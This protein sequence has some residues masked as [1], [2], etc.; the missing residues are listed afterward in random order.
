MFAVFNSVFV[1]SLKIRTQSAFE[2]RLSSQK[3]SLITVS[4]QVGKQV[5]EI[6]ANLHNIKQRLKQAA[7]GPGLRN[8]IE[9]QLNRLLYSGYLRYTPLAQLQAIPRYLKAI[10]CRLD[11]QKFDSADVQGLQRLQQQYWQQVQKQLKT[12]QPMPE[13]DLFR[14]SLEELRVSLFAQ[15]LKTAYPVSV[16]RLEKQWN[17]MF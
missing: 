1:E 2:A 17:E 11:K 15:Q 8:D 12:V 7:V 5:S 6:M 4:A 3:S 14:W 13:L 10:E 9:E 16:Q